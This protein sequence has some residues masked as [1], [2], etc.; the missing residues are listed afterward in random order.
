MFPGASPPRSTN[1]S[2]LQVSY[3]T[4]G[5]L[6]F[7]VL[8]VLPG[9]SSDPVKCVLQTKSLNDPSLG[10]TA[11][12]W[13][14][15]PEPPKYKVITVNGAPHSIRPSLH[16][17]LQNLRHEDE[18][19]I[20]W[21]DAISI[22]QR[23][24]DEKAE[25]IPLMAKIYSQA[26]FVAVW[27]GRA[28]DDSD[29]IMKCL[30]QNIVPKSARFYDGLFKLLLRPWFGRS[31]VLQEF[32]LNRNE[33]R[34]YVGRS[35]GASWSTLRDASLDILQSDRLVMDSGFSGAGLSGQFAK[36][37]MHM[38]SLA[39]A[40]DIYFSGV[41]RGDNRTL[42][43]WL[44][45]LQYMTATDPRDKIYG[46]LGLIGPESVAGF[47]KVCTVTYTKS[48]MDTYRDATLFMLT[49]EWNFRAY[50]HYWTFGG[51]GS[52]GPSWTL[53]FKCPYQPSG[54]VFRHQDAAGFMPVRV[55]DDRNRLFVKAILLD[56]V[57]DL[58][59][60]GDFNDGYGSMIGSKLRQI[61]PL[62]AK[63]YASATRFGHFLVVLGLFLG[64]KRGWRKYAIRVAQNSVK[65]IYAI[66]HIDELLNQKMKRPNHMF[67]LAEPLWKTFLGHFHDQKL[68]PEDFPDQFE[69]ALELA[70]QFTG[71]LLDKIKA[72][73]MFDN[74]IL[75][76]RKTFFLGKSSGYGMTEATV[77]KGD[78]LALLFP[79][80]FIPFLVRPKGSAYELIGPA[81]VPD[82]F[83]ERLISER[84]ET[85]HEITIV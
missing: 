35:A 70:R 64:K 58:V 55:S 11:L 66:R 23:D 9:R 43:Y 81:Y 84:R 22:N 73:T 79:E 51:N 48:M 53:D 38:T 54:A 27:L 52:S 5:R 33:P 10:Y 13:T 21:I 60:I 31:W 63:Q 45:F 46:I 76:S 61:A 65:Y 78:I 50:L 85:L 80:N 77:Q 59:E 34:F 75:V 56:E 49:E 71:S 24:T 41:S 18:T 15:G 40:R 39:S 47:E 82:A 69:K 26:Q 20:F 14:W 19:Q 74:G 67:E 16:D 29:F 72:H 68:R 8:T 6:Q 32:V 3:D 37:L 44:H 4:L 12:S 17:A 42:S 2:Q 1:P 36:I 25:Q 62:T 28:A 7:R 83:K 30:S 57:E